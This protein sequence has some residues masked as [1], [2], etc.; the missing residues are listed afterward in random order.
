[1]IGYTADIIIISDHAWYDW[2]KCSDLVGKQFP[3][4]NM[5]LGRHLG[6]AI[7]LEPAPT[8]KI[9]KSNGELVHRSTYHSILPEEVNDEK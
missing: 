1:M 2:I 6:P 5:Y 3:E 4:E 9:L 8:A 7:Y